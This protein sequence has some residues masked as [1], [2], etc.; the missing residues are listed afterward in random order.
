MSELLHPMGSFFLCYIDPEDLLDS[1]TQGHRWMW[2]SWYEKLENVSSDVMLCRC[3]EVM[4]CS[5]QLVPVQ[6]A[7]LIK[8]GKGFELLP[9]INGLNCLK[10]LCG[11]SRHLSLF[12]HSKHVV[13]T[14]LS[15]LFA[16]GLFSKHC[17][18]LKK[19]L[20][21]DLQNILDFA[22]ST[23]QFQVLEK[24]IYILYFIC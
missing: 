6:Q 18:L 13:E 14:Q 10:L 9:H 23:C 19:S 8:P 11:M 4:F 16:R 7:S 3:V 17:A 5:I 1:V 22:L 15:S 20:D 12:L 21:I 2:Q 24:E